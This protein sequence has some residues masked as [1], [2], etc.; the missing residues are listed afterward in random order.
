VLGPTAVG[1]LVDAFLEVEA[2]VRVN[3]QFDAA[4][5]EIYDGLL[6]RIAHVPGASLVAAVLARSAQ[7]DNEQMARFA[8]LLS[9]HPD[10]DT[11]RGRPFDPASLTAIQGLVEDWASRMLASGDAKRWHKASIATLASHT[12]SVS[13][14]P[15]LKRLLNDNL[16]RYR[17]FREQVK[18]TGRQQGE[19][20][21]EAR[22]PMTHEYQ[23]AFL[24]IKSPETA[25]MMREYLLDE[26][27]GALAAEVLANQWRTAN[28]PP[29][30]K[31]LPFG[32]H[33]AGVEEK[34]AAR[35]ADPDATSAEAEAIFAA[36][37]PLIA[38]GATDEQKELAV[39]LGIVASRLPHGRR[40]STL[41]KLIALAPRSARS[42]LLLG[43][44]LSG[45][46]IDIKVVA[47][48][49][50]ETLEAAKTETWI[51]TQ[52]DG[53]ELNRWLRL[54]PFVS[55]P[56]E[57]LAVVRGMPPAQ[58]EP[59]FLE[60]MVGALADASSGE[61]EEVSFKLAEEDPRFYLNDRWRT[62]ALRFGTRSSA[63]RIVDL[64][65]SGAL[66]R[67]RD[68]WHLAREL[69]S[70][71]ATHPD[72]RS[73]VYN[74]LKDGPTTLGLAILTRAVA[75]IPD[76]DGLLLLIRFEQELKGAFVTLRTIE[77]LVT[78]HVPASDWAGAYNVVPAPAGSLRQ[79]LLALTTD[80]G[81]ADAAARC[82]RQI[83][84]IRDE[85]GMPEAEPRHPDLASGKPWPIMQ[86]DPEAVAEW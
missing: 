24:A 57:A 46:E 48:G 22:Q 56:T 81:P 13:L 29:K 15:I 5:S 53:Y 50:S 59:R 73:H 10:G 39:S 11:D 47:D 26:D 30:D 54:L 38:D 31:R 19:A 42:N 76:E 79:K 55:R 7:A 78:E 4:G 83:D 71:I 14:L 2:R 8:E 86:P 85:H 64:T 37:E 75:E 21:S 41:Q 1:R 44:V 67:T 49:I 68:D 45:E 20:M 35:A 16:Q 51:L 32:L 43:L 40:D 80:G 65:A 9:Q 74:L 25:A 66:D 84:W 60:E 27:F 77:R 70:L 62:T 69:G 6:T 52:S 36:I 17:A 34:R 3:G 61:A 23:R 72:L 28:E 12:P 82:L 18:A 58:R 33:F 63:R